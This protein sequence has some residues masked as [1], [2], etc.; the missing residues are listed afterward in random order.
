MPIEAFNI[1]LEGTQ[2]NQQCDNKKKVVM[3]R[4]TIQLLKVFC[5][6]DLK[7]PLLNY[8]ANYFSIKCT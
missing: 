1:L 7:S 6:F 4:Y 8:F 2:N 5:G 3:H